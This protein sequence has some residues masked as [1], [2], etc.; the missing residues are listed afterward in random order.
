MTKMKLIHI[1]S[2]IS[3]IVFMQTSCKSHQIKAS[4][5][6]MDTSTI[7]TSIGKIACYI[8]EVKG[9]TPIL[10]LHGVYYDHNLWNYQVSRITDQTTIAID[11]PLHGRSKE[12]IADWNMDDCSTMLIEILN[13]LKI[14]KCYAIGH[15]WG[16]MTILRAA[17]Q[18][19]E[20]FLGVGFCNMP[21]EKGGFGAKLQ[22]GA[23]HTLLPFRKFYTKQVAKAMF[24]KSSRTEKPEIVEYL[25]VTMSQLSNKEIR[26][27]DKAVISHV[28]SGYPFLDSMTVPALALKGRDDYVPDLQNIETEI[29]EGRHTSPLEEAEKVMEM[30]VKLIEK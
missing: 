28:G 27:T 5:K 16:S 4:N 7:N 29:V 23:L 25:E 12:I 26:R 11:M 20:R 21:L 18:H 8:N 24:G 2:V 30:I 19:P 13:D 17:S 9:T 3:I 22:F 1:I 15:S 14:E 6:K 10:F